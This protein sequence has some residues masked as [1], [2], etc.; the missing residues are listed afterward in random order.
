MDVTLPSPYADPEK[1]TIM[2]AIIGIRP[3]YAGAGAA[4]F[5][6]MASSQAGVVHAESAHPGG[7]LKV[8]SRLTV[9]DATDNEYASVIQQAICYMSVTPNGVASIQINAIFRPVTTL[10]SGT[11]DDE[12]GWSAVDLRWS[13]LPA[14]WI[15][16]GKGP[17]RLTQVAPTHW[18]QYA[19]TDFHTH[20]WGP[21]RWP[22]KNLASAEWTYKGPVPE[23]PFDL[24]VGVE[25]AHWVSADDDSV[26]SDGDAE[27][28]L[29]TVLVQMS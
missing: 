22:P 19:D 18:R 8:V 16:V 20:A 21:L 26:V 12:L 1:G 7:R 2:P 25:A 14:C 15:D 6:P 17:V 27:F 23:G 3:P 24:Y 10:Y 5:G 9:T 13:L 29:S 4:F 28:H 11:I